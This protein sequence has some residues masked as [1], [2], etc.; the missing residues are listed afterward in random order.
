MVTGGRDQRG[1][2]GRSPSKS[3]DQSVAKGGIVI[4]LLANAM[5]G[6]FKLRFR[7]LRLATINDIPSERLAEIGAQLKAEGWK[8]TYEYDRFDAWIDHGCV[9]LKKDGVKL[10]IEWD[11]YL[12]GSIEGPKAVICEMADRFELPVSEEWRWHNSVQ[13]K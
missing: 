2:A 9:K 12:E 3:V 4:R 11:P 7:V 8:K 1:K 13:E 5:R 6:F 10:K